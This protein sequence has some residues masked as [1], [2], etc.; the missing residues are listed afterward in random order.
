LQTSITT[1][2]EGLVWGKLAINAGINPLTALLKV[3]NGFLIENK[4]ARNLMVEAAEE[5]AAVASKL[6]IALPYE[7]AGE[8]AIKVARQTAQN[9]SSMLQDILR[10]APTE[11]DAICGEIVNYGRQIGVPTPINREFQRLISYETNL[12]S[13]QHASSK[14]VDFNTLHNGRAKS[15]I[16]SLV[17]LLSNVDVSKDSKIS[18]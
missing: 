2:V 15:N 5:T 17:I 10:Q 13:S 12:H 18:E 1:D 4:L 7:S 14:A 8:Q 3:R 11:I 6:G 16:R 9:Y